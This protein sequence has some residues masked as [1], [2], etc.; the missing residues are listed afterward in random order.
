MEA[1]FVFGR[2]SVTPSNPAT[3]ELALAVSQLHQESKAR[4]ESAKRIS[5]GKLDGKG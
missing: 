2:K 5:F 3:T 1:A 4:A